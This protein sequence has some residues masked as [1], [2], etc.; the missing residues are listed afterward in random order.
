MRIV[1]TIVCLYALWWIAYRVPPISDCREIRDT[2]NDASQLTPGLVP[3]W[4]SFDVAPCIFMPSSEREQK[5]TDAQV[6][7]FTAAQ[8]SQ[9]SEGGHGL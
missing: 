6:L 5:L 7:R 4:D 9:A 1:W 8:L 2:L 3:T